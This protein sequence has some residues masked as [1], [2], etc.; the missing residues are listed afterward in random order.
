MMPCIKI[1]GI[2]YNTQQPIKYIVLLINP[3]LQSHEIKLLSSERKTRL[4]LAL[5]GWRMEDIVVEFE[6]L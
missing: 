1:N 6:D 2:Q 4:F 5:D 3:I